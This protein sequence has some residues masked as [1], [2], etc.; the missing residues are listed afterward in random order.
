M[1][2]SGESFRDKG[3]V[4]M[5]RL[6]TR[7]AAGLSVALSAA[8][9]YATNVLTNH[10]N[11]GLAAGGT[12]LLA[13]AIWLAIRTAPPAQTTAPRTTVLVKAGRGSRITG[14][15][16][17]ATAG[18]DVAQTAQDGGIIRDSTIHATSAKVVRRA[19][20][21]TIDHDDIDAQ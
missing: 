16:T 20:G 10:W 12:A 18:A 5:P 8:L 2:L 17:D 19:D 3:N 4:T 21:G 15:R 9:G 6:G 1:H 14:T 7:T 11:W 13:A